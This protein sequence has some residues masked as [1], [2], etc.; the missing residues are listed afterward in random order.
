MGMRVEDAHPQYLIERSLLQFQ[1]TLKSP[2]L[3]KAI[4]ETKEK[5]KGLALPEGGAAAEEYYGFKGELARVQKEFKLKKRKSKD[6]K[7]E[8]F[9]EAMAQWKDEKSG[10]PKPEST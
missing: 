10:Q 7:C 5:L 3:Q 8:P 4:D 2:E 6:Q 1:S 9:A